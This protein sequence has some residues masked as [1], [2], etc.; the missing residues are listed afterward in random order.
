[1]SNLKAT[2]NRIDINLNKFQP[3]TMDDLISIVHSTTGVNNYGTHFTIVKYMGYL[4]GIRVYVTGRS[5][6]HVLPA[7][8][9]VYSTFQGIEKYEKAGYQ[10]ENN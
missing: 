2:L 5:K 8:G 10:I 4:Q 3:K 6:S 1:M 7:K 9:K